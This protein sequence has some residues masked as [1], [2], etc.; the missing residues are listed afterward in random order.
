MRQVTA[1]SLGTRMAFFVTAWCRC[2][3]SQVQNLP[4]QLNCVTCSKNKYTF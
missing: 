1:P 4:W 3:L 2:Y